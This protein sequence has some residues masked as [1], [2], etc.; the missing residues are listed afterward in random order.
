MSHNYIAD[1]EVNVLVYDGSLPGR[2]RWIQIP[3]YMVVKLAALLRDSEASADEFNGSLAE[4]LRQLLDESAVGN[5]S[6]AG[7]DA[8]SNYIWRAAVASILDR[9]GVRRWQRKLLR[10]RTLVIKLEYCRLGWRFDLRAVPV[11]CRP[12]IGKQKAS[13]EAGT[14][15]GS[16]QRAS[17]RVPALSSI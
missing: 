16:S 10:E 1:T 3:L 2:A 14:L 6:P 15:L 9:Y 11:D 13:H 7:P 12:H 8:S 17:A 5:D 4:L